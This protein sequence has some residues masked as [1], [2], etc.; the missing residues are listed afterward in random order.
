LMGVPLKIFPFFPFFPT[1]PAASSTGSALAAQLSHPLPA[2]PVRCQ[3][4][5]QQNQGVTH[6]IGSA[7]SALAAERHKS[8]RPLPAL[9]PS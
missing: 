5:M 8:E 1:L 6:T 3:L 9:P 4:D 2:L 7:G